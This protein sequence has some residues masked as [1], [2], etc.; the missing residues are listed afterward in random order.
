[1]SRYDNGTYIKVLDGDIHTANQKAAGLD[2]RAQAKTFI[3]ALV[4]GCGAAKMGEILGKD[5]KAG[6]KIISDFMKRT[7]AL[8]R[9]IEDVQQKAT[10][11]YIKVLMVGN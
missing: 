10:K 7:P 4:Y 3:Y 11:G 2:T 6:K 1:M 5:V 9:L 8:K